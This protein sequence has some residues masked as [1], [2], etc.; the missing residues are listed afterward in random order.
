M[1]K[2]HHVKDYSW[3]LRVSEY[4]YMLSTAVAETESI[5]FIPHQECQITMVSMTEVGKRIVSLK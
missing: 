4:V 5:F 1:T 3:L 2:G